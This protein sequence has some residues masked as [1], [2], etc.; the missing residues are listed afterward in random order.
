M[1]KQAKFY[2]FPSISPGHLWEALPF[3]DI[4]KT[5]VRRQGAWV[6]RS[7][8]GLRSRIIWLCKDGY[9]GLWMVGGLGGARQNRALVEELDRE[10]MAPDCLKK[11]NWES[12]TLDKST[13][14][15]HDQLIVPLAKYLEAHTKMEIQEMG[16]RVGIPIMPVRTP[17]LLLKDDQLAG[18]DYWVEIEHPELGTTI[19]Y[20]GAFI[21]MSETPLNIGQ[22][23]PLI[24][25]HNE[26]IYKYELGM[27]TEELKI[28]M[29][30]GSI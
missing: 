16:L 12:Y 21:K 24:G 27:S 15:E 18:R 2:S 9:V 19:T 13:Q 4:G 29:E 10:G 11:K 1:V 26:Q 25:E 30:G 22:R 7:L 14:T 17:A 20:P 5:V 8:S 6:I 28:L 23:A 3:W